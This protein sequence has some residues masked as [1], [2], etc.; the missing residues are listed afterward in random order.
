MHS[1]RLSASS[2]F[3]LLAADSNFKWERQRIALSCANPILYGST[4]G[5]SAVILL[6]KKLIARI[7]QGSAVIPDGEIVRLPTKSLVGTEAMMMTN[8]RC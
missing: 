6:Q 1:N 8:L 5:G 4:S 2:F 7:P 3:F